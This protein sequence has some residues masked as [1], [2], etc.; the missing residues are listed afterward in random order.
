MKTETPIRRQYLEIKKKHRDAILLFRL[1]DFYEAFDDDARLL[2]REL[3]IVLTSKPMGKGLRVPLA[4]V[5]FHALERHLATLISRGHRVAICEQ[6]SDTPIK[7][8]GGTRLIERDVVRVVTPG[9]VFEP[10]LL[11]GKNNNFI[12][13]FCSDGRRAGIAFADVSTND[14]AATEIENHQALPELQRIAPSEI[15]IAK[16][17][18]DFSNQ[19]LPGFV[20]QIGEKVFAFETARKTLLQHFST[21]TLEP[22]GLEK[23]PLA[24]SAAAAIVFYLRETQAASVE[25]L[26]RLKTYDASQF[27]ALDAH[28]IK[29]LEVFESSSGATSLL[30]VL[31]KTRTAM[32]GRLLRRWLRQPLMDVAEIVKRQEHIQFFVENSRARAEIANVLENLNDIERLT[33]RAKTALCSAQELLALGKSLEKIPQIRQILQQDLAR[34]GKTLVNLPVCEEAANTIANAINDELP[35]YKNEQTGCIRAGFSE[36]LDK[37]RSILRDGK[38]F[39]ADLEARLRARSGIKSLRVAYNKVFGYFIEI[40]KS[41]LHLAPS[42]F[43]R[44][45][46]LVNAERFVTLELKEYESLV[47]NSQERLSELENSIFRQVCAQVGKQRTQILAAA[48]TIAYLDA[49]VSLA[50]TADENN[51]SKPHVNDTSLLRIKN[52]RH[53]IVEQSH[54]NQQHNFVANDA[55]LGGNGAPNIALITGP[56]ASGKST[57]LRQIALIVLMAQIGSF[58]P[59]EDAVIGLCDRVFTRIGLYDRIGL[60]ESTFMT[61]MVETAEILHNATARSLILLD[62]LGRGTSTYD[63]LAV[64][65]SVIEFVHNHPKLN[66]RTVFATHYHELTELENL[67]PRLKNYRV[68]IEEKGDELEFL[69]KISAGVA[70]RSYG[71]YAAKLAGLPKPVVRR[72]EELLREYEG[73]NQKFEISNLKSS[74][75]S[76]LEKAVGA[77]DLDSLSP[78]EALMKLYELKGLSQKN[79]TA[80]KLKSA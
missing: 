32:G 34:F 37:L 65:R 27:M 74:N 63:G 38:Q 24:M 12:A 30:S 67:L 55:A 7:G 58:V 61:E 50:E 2:A 56:N 45:Q 54:K 14:F 17:E 5:P 46:T 16:S 72:A 36:E 33:V 22:F 3:D 44:K 52:G 42:D 78:V 70:L 77:L 19:N 73:E 43:V 62:E 29:S 57:Y 40:S 51:Y 9:T 53:P 20:T 35:T 39:L 31:D 4:G 64:A 59:A 41:N 10:G 15:L 26:T 79:E 47:L 23:L 13:A 68:E 25:Q 69:Y 48:T 6:L 76:E 8:E 18:N 11:D 1:G 60:G 28:T 49:I 21:K 80:R 75:S 66:A 71:V